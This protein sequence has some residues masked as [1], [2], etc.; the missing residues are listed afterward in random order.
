MLYFFIFVDPGNCGETDLNKLAEA[1]IDF[2]NRPMSSPKRKFFFQKKLPYHNKLLDVAIVEIQNDFDLLPTKLSLRKERLPTNYDY[3]VVVSGFGHVKEKKHIERCP[4]LHSDAAIIEEAKKYLKDN[5]SNLKFCLLPHT[6]YNVVE[7]GYTGYD[8]EHKLIVNTYM[9]KGL[10][11]S[12]MMARL[13]HDASLEVVGVFT[14]AM[15]ECFFCLKAQYQGCFPLK[16]R[17]EA[18]T[19]MISVFNDMKHRHYTEYIQDMFF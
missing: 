16:Y 12:P 17:F 4:V 3:E 13:N 19:R 10:S 6:P 9:E 1:Y 15:P 11:G 8:E 18:G 2:S 7:K 5:A 14:H